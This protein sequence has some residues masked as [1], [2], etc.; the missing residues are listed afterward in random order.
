MTAALHQTPQNNV[1]GAIVVQ[2][3]CILSY[4]RLPVLK[5]SKISWAIGGGPRP[6]RPPSKYAHDDIMCYFH[7]PGDSTCMSEMTATKTNSVFTK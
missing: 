4:I 2:F 5:Q 7:S 1:F 6:P 3:W